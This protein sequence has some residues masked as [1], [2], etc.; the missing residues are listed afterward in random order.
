MRGK[1]RCVKLG[2][3]MALPATGLWPKLAGKAARKQDSMPRD[4]TPTYAVLIDAENMPASLADPLFRAVGLLGDAPVRR[5]YGDFS[6]GHLRSWLPVIPRY[7][8]DPRQTPFSG[9]GKNATDIALVIDAMDLLHSGRFDGFCIVSSDSDFTRLATRIR[10]EGLEV[11]G[12]GQAK[13]TEAFRQACKLFCQVE[14]DTALTA[15][16]PP[17]VAVPLIRR[18]ADSSGDREGWVS[19]S[20]LGSELRRLAPG[21]TLRSF[22]SSKLSDLIEATGQFELDRAGGRFRKRLRLAAANAT[23]A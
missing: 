3:R 7:A 22:G 4:E 6:S 9:G 14:T 8:I 20:Q 13:T 2:A 17:S 11:Y 12:F 5:I 16:T 23:H 15:P 19:L 21:F 18:V 1:P 10:E